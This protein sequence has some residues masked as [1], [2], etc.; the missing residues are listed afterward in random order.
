[1]ALQEADAPHHVSI[2]DLTT[3]GRFNYGGNLKHTFTAHPKIC[4]AT[5]EMLFFGYSFSKKPHLS[6]SGRWEGGIGG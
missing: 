6:Y 2:P 4:G 1:M 3:V 5:G